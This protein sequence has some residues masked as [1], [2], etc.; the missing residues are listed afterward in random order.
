MAKK[1]EKLMGAIQVRDLPQATF[2]KLTQLMLAEDPGANLSC[3]NVLRWAA[4]R[5]A[6]G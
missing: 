5:A 1:T 2:D 4:I 3:A 6:K